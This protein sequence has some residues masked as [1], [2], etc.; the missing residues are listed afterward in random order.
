M[1]H[2]GR[3]FLEKLDLLVEIRSIR[4][5]TSTLICYN[6]NGLW[7]L[8]GYHLWAGRNTETDGQLSLAE[9][10]LDN[11]PTRGAKRAFSFFS[12]KTFFFISKYLGLFVGERTPHSLSTCYVPPVLW[13]YCPHLPQRNLPPP[14]PPSREVII[15]PAVVP[16]GATFIL[17][18]CLPSCLLLGQALLHHRGWVSFRWVTSAPSPL[19]ELS[20]SVFTTWVLC[21]L[22]LTKLTSEMVRVRSGAC[23]YSPKACLLPVTLLCVCFV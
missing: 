1:D 7:C 16:A 10:A 20:E 21:D 17:C 22:Y 23:V 14:P 15:T 8:H 5:K 11:T 9:L 13:T 19:W 18:T 4:P 6:I 3:L 12:Y 2:S